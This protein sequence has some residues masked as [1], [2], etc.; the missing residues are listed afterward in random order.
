MMKEKKTYF[1][2][3]LLYKVFFKAKRL[4]GRKRRLFLLPP[5]EPQEE[6]NS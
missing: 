4:F 1:D 5:L 3:V 6:G 2:P